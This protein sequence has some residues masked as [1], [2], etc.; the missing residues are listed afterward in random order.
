MDD[1]LSD[2]ES[3]FLFRLFSDPILV[4]EYISELVRVNSD[5]YADRLLEDLKDKI[6]AYDYVLQ[7]NY[8]FKDIQKDIEF[9]YRNR[10]YIRKNYLEKPDVLTARLIKRSPEEIVL[11]LSGSSVIPLDVIGVGT[12]HRIL[13][14][15]EKGTIGIPGINQRQPTSRTVRFVPAEGTLP[16]ELDGSR[17]SVNYRL[18]GTAKMRHAVVN[19]EVPE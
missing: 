16:G 9:L 12:N 17:L 13:F 3:A 19:N 2:P 18:L 4:R 6:E 1:R 8:P 15:P 10:D 5:E 14:R 11:N 7:K